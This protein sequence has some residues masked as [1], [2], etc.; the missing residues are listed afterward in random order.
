MAEKNK[1]PWRKHL[2]EEWE[3]EKKKKNPDSFS[4][5]MKKAKKNYKK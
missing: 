1:N 5:V 3:K 4:E 2:M